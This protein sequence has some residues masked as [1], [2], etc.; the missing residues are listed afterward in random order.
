M[1]KDGK[2]LWRMSAIEYLSTA[3]KKYNQKIKCLG[4]L[5]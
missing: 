4:N 2:K 5:R 1:K 3:L